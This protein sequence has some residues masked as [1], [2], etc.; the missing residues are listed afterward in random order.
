MK[1]ITKNTPRTEMFEAYKEAKAE[2]LRLKRLHGNSKETKTRVIKHKNEKYDKLSYKLF[3]EKQKVYGKDKHI[4]NL[5]RHIQTKVAKAKRTGYE[6][7]IAQIKERDG[8]IIDMYTFLNKINVVTQIMGMSLNECAFILW[9]GTY[10]FYGTKDFKRDW[11]ETGVS[12]YNMNNR[13]VKRN[14]IAAID[15]LDNRKKTFALTA[16]GLDMFSKIDKFTKKQFEN[17]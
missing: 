15:Q 17:E 8:R 12:F 16:T 4:D 3:K 10:N 6:K 5:R 1:Y 13:M 14:Y 2:I 9:A 7:A 11:P